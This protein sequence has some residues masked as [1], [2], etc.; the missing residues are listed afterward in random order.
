VTATAAPQAGPVTTTADLDGNGEIE[1]VTTTM[2]GDNDQV[3][4]ATVNG[5]PTSIHLPADTQAGLQAPRA[6]DLNGDG[7]Q[8]LLV[9]TSVGAN[10]TQFAALHYHDGLHQIAGPDDKPLTLAEGGGVATKLG[11]NCSDTEG[12]GRAFGT[13]TAEADDLNA[14]SGQVTYTGTRTVYTLRDG[15]L[16]VQ[17]TT[18][19]THRADTDPLVIADPATCS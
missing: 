5:V 12:G 13:V 2:A 1:T 11:Y 9:P 18:P 19:F 16:T 4:S 7:S 8:E 10:T 14:P 6:A 17:D 15:A 3:I